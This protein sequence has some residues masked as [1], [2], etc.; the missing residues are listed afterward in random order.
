MLI[1]LAPAAL[2]ATLST[3]N[4]AVG[5]NSDGSLVD[6]GASVGLIYDPRRRGGTDPAGLGPAAPGPSVGDMDARDRPATR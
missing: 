1:L 5:V 3:S 6:D 2:A 4:V